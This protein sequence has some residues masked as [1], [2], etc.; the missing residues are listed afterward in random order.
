MAEQQTTK[1]RTKGFRMTEKGLVEP[2]TELDV[3]QHVAAEMVAGGTVDLVNEN[4]RG[5]VDQA[6]AKY[7]EMDAQA[8]GAVR[9]ERKPDVTA[10][11]VANHN[12]AQ[13]IDESATTGVYPTVEVKRGPGRPPKAQVE[14]VQ[15]AG[16]PAVAEAKRG[17][18]RPAKGE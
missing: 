5:T 6:L 3:P 18:G 1:V 11:A 7:R 14:Q 4:D 17:P 13:G 2:G 10:L 9:V 8:R 16:D 15:P 12:A